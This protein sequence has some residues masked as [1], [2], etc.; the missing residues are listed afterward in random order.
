MRS[1]HARSGA[2]TAALVCTLATIAGAQPRP[3]TLDDIYDPSRRINFAGTPLPA[4]TW[5]DASR[6]V[7]A[8][9][10]GDGPEWQVVDA[11][12]GSATTLF[13]AGRLDAAL[14]TAGAA[15]DA[16][17]AAARARS[18][19]FDRT[20]SALVLLVAGDVYVYSIAPNRAVRLTTTSAAEEV[21]S[22]SPDGARVAYVRQGNLYVAEIASR[23]ET[24]LT[25]DG[26][27]RILNGRLD[28]VYEEEIF[29]RGQPRA[30]WW[31]P[32]STRLAYL[33]LDDTLVP[34]FTV[35]DH[36]P[37][38]QGV[39]RWY[40]PKVG[41][42]NPIVTLGVA[43]A[44]G[45]RTQWVDVGR[46]PAPERLIAAVSWTADS[47]D[48]VYQAQNRA[49]T[50]LDVNTA[51]AASGAT[52]TLFRETSRAWV[53][54][55]ADPVWLGDG[56]F[57]WLSERS[58]YRHLY[59]YGSDGRLRRQLTDGPWEVRSLYGVDEAGGWVYFAGTERSATGGD[60]YRVRLGGAGSGGSV[61]A[62]RPERLSATPGLHAAEF[63][64]G[65]RYFADSWSDIRTPPQLRLFRN[66]GSELRAIEANRV[67]VLDQFILPPPE[68]LQ[69]ETRD[70]F[71]MEAMLIKP[72]DFDAGRRYP[73]YT[74]VYG[75]PHAQRVRNAWSGETLFLQLLAQQGVV[76]WVCDNRTASGKGAD[77]TWPVYRNFGELELRDLEDGLAWLRAQPYIDAQRIG[78]HGWS[79]GGYLTA[80]ALTHSRSFVMGIAGGTVSDWRN[81]DSVYTERYMGPLAENEEGYKKS[82]PRFAAASLH[83][84]L[85]LIHGLMDDNVHVDNTIQ[86]A[87]ELQKAQKPF[88][89]MLYPKSRHG[90]TDPAL[91]RHMR[92]LMFDFVMRHLK[93]ERAGSAAG[94]AGTP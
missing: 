56:S 17:R 65:F 31:S 45:G 60:I 5:I 52:R 4:L 16:A 71:T 34:S 93:P 50:W 62:D 8:R 61:A 7:L 25:T 22:F 26:T 88:E 55:T 36:I 76:V 63:S 48:V 33:R 54:D 23:R 46:Y 3:L 85:L 24:A 81:Y 2:V 37:Y 12:S 11:E 84:S 80:Y 75:G 64:P 92:G 40:Y 29:G 73:V 82:S 66:D 83:G 10:G 49:Q 43:P 57:L 28:W 77:A 68:F 69:V 74:Y 14:V 32:D 91:V 27:E 58:G 19:T 86:M 41:D 79:Y 47:R 39:E 59:L 89:L 67:D 70:G 6:Y 1:P 18:L 35:V 42:P 78:I 15:A 30:Y 94:A 87:Y 20:G 38:E 51:D 21:P 90:V 13:A 53:S 72:P 9:A 44:I